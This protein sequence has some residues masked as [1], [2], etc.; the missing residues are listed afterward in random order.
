MPTQE[1]EDLCQDKL[2]LI[3]G[4]L[5]EGRVEPGKEDGYVWRCGET[6]AIS[7]FRKTRRAPVLLEEGQE[8]EIPAPTSSQDGT[9]KEKKL[10]EGVKRL[11]EVLRSKALSPAEQQLLQD[12]Y[13]NQV[14]IG[15]LAERELQQNPLLLRGPHAGTRRTLEQAR[16]SVDQRLTRA[17]LKLTAAMKRA[18]SGEQRRTWS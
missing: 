16:N 2:L 12:V 11:R 14:P 5:V 13:V 8:E 1:V 9:R 15:E 17:R 10:E 7:F 6:L 4:K 3:L 18:L